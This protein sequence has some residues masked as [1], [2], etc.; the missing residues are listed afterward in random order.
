[1]PGAKENR[2]LLKQVHRKA[3]GKVV[4][5]WNS[6]PRGALQVAEWINEKR[7]QKIEQLVN[8]YFDMS[9]S[10]IH[11]RTR[12][13][14]A[15]SKRLIGSLPCVWLCLF[16]LSCSY[17]SSS[18]RVHGSSSGGVVSTAASASLAGVNVAAAAEPEA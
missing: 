3:A 5:D 2:K 9:D 14:P 18:S 13:A 17:F 12:K 8:K 10:N 16:L 4:D 11:T 7:K 15:H 1:M 6:K